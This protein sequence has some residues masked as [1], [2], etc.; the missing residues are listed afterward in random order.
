MEVIA[1]FRFEESMWCSNVSLDS[2]EI[3]AA[4]RAP[5]KAPAWRTDTTFPEKLLTVLWLTV[6]SASW[7]NCFWKVLCETTEPATPLEY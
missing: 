1:R 4:P 5:K 6:P 7:K 2:P 3:G